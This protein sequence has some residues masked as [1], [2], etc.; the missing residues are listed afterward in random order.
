MLR[1]NCRDDAGAGRLWRGGILGGPGCRRSGVSRS[2]STGRLADAAMRTANAESAPVRCR[3]WL[4]M[5]MGGRA[6]GGQNDPVAWLA[7]FRL[8][9]SAGRRHVRS[10]DLSN[11]LAAP[12]GA[13]L[14]F[15]VAFSSV[16]VFG[17]AQP[18][19]G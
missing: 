19:R 13:V 15:R 17:L 6:T 2:C 10:C 8:E 11:M 16:V 18:M 4:G 3:C 9:L 7:R 12:S 5:I 14:L 1:A